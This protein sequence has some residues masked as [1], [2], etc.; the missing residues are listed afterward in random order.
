M[1]KMPMVANLKTT[2]VPLAIG[3]GDYPLEDNNAFRGK[4]AVTILRGCQ[5]SFYL[6]FFFLT[7]YLT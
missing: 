5:A 1:K 3:Q 4:A 6:I 7:I 2:N